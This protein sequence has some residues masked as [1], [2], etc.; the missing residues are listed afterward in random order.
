MVSPHYVFIRVANETGVSNNNTD[1]ILIMR[2][3]QPSVF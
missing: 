3:E 2:L 1:I